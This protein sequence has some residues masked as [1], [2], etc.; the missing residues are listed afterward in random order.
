MAGEKD[1]DRVHFRR[2]LDLFEEIGDLA[3][4]A[5]AHIELAHAYDHEDRYQARLGSPDQA[6]VNCK[7]SLALHQRIGDRRGQAH[8][9]IYLGDSQHAAGNPAAA[10]RSWQQALNILDQLGHTIRADEV[11]TKLTELDAAAPLHAE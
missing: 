4:Q 9:L 1:E 8:T 10:G 5:C 11:R 6:I 3:G 2:A 7:Q